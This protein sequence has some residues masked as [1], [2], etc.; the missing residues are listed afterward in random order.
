M[1][2]KCPRLPSSVSTR[3]IDGR[4][5]PRKVSFSVVVTPLL[6]IS[7]VSNQ[8]LSNDFYV[9]SGIDRNATVLPYE[10]VQNYFVHLCATTDD[11]EMVLLPF[12]RGSLYRMGEKQI[13]CL[14]VVT[15]EGERTFYVLQLLFGRS[16]DR[17][18][19]TLCFIT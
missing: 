5:I 15:Y 19:F 1:K 14:N 2:I 10:N 9:L 16:N 6:D 18:R 13:I 3:K 7:F 17:G 8:F 4:R 12:R 11:D